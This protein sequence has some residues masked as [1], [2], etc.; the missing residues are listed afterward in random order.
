M[1]TTQEKI[2][3]KESELKEQDISE[4]IYIPELKIEVQN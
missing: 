4:W 2:E 1:K 3:K